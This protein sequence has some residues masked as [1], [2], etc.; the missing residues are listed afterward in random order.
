MHEHFL[1][2]GELL[3]CKQSVFHLLSR[4]LAAYFCLVTFFLEGTKDC[5]Q[6]C[7]YAM[8]KLP[9]SLPSQ[10]IP[11]SKKSTLPICFLKISIIE[12]LNIL[13]SFMYVNKIIRGH[14]LKELR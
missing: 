8:P 5:I 3:S 11:I 4:N 13:L 6:D 10:F 7:F 2:T 9:Y 1:V 14:H 12:L